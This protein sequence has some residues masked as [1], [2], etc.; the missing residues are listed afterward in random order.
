MGT[1]GVPGT[2]QG[3]R[4][5]R[6]AT[7]AG[8]RRRPGAAHGGS[9]RQLPGEGERASEWSERVEGGEEVLTEEGIGGRVTGDDAVAGRAVAAGV[10]EE[11][12]RAAPRWRRPRIG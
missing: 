7:G 8:W 10:G 5:R 11:P 4:R 6:R 3:G 9:R 1:R 12:A 2:L